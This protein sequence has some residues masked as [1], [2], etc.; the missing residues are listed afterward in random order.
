[1]KN[2]HT[3]EWVVRKNLC[4]GCGV[5]A[6]VCPQQAITCHEK[7]A[8][9]VPRIDKERCI[10]DKGCNQCYKVCPGQG[11]PLAKA[12]EEL[13][14]SAVKDDPYIGKYEGSYYGWSTD[15]SIRYHSASG[16]MLSHFLIYLLENNII[17]GALVTKFSDANP[18]RS[19]P[20]LATTRDEVLSAKS[21]K[22][23]PVSLHGMIKE[24]EAFS[25]KVAIV[26]L[27]CHIQGLRKYEK[28][29][30]NFK[31]KIFGYFAIYCSS[32]RNYKAIDWLLKKHNIRYD[33]VLSFSFR[34]EGCLGSLVIN[35]EKVTIKEK[36]ID[37]YGQLRSYFKPKRCSFCIDHYG[38]LSDISFGDIHI[39]PYFNEVG[40]NSV[41]VRN[42]N[43]QKYLK[44]AKEDGIFEMWNISGSEV[45]R[46]QQMLYQ[47]RNITVPFFM[48]FERLIGRSVPSYDFDIPKVQ[49]LKG[50]RYWISYCAQRF[51]GRYF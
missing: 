9:I 36:Y 4:L 5:C 17:Q 40:V 13:Y 16:G 22:Y 23:C 30:N 18:L 49:F 14:G 27:P 24:I 51:I 2:A 10:N 20:F 29:N 19:M 6:D 25:G 37:Y 41:I 42:L 43:I 12:S 47:N 1:M 8:L 15:H 35:T 31:E 26:G 45:N 21:S 48:F 38:M 34:D 44:Q 7:N 39:Q 50:A 33:D 3:I 11:M 46:S 32:T 28:I